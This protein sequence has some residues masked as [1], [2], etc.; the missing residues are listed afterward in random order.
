VTLASTANS[1]Q[2][3][4]RKKTQM[5]VTICE[6]GKTCFARTSQWCVVIVDAEDGW[7]LRKYKWTAHITGGGRSPSVRC[8]TYAYETGKSALLHRAVTGHAY[9]LM[10]HIN[11]NAHDNRKANLRLCRLVRLL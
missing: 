1:H 5:Q 9:P 4:R 11:R 8:N 3:Q 2:L 7:L 10:D 6:C